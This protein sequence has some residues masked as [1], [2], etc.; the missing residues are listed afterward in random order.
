MKKIIS[1]LSR[2]IPF[3]NKNLSIGLA[4]IAVLFFCH[5]PVIAQTK[6]NN[7]NPNAAANDSLRGITIHQEI[8]FKISSRRVYDALLSSKQFSE[9]TKKSFADF[10]SMSAKIDSTPGGTFSVFDGHI[11]G[12]ILELVPNVR[13][14]EAWRVVDWPAG[15]YSIAKFEFKAQGTGTQL[16]FD[17]T[18][19]PLGLKQHLAIGWQQHYWDALIK[20]FQ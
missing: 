9:C 4:F 16:I 8:Y 18:G 10:S 17:H 3:G 7:T 1:V 19:F 2:A 5:F 20:Y 12:R 13:I 11:I 6:M 15:I 14:V